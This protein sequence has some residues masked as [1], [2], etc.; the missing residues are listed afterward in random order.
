MTCMKNIN[1]IDNTGSLAVLVLQT[2]IASYPGP[3]VPH[4]GMGTRLL[5]TEIN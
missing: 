2:Y 3:H 1:M 4:V 5:Q